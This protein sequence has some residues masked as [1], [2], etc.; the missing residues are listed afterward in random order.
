[1]ASDVPPVDLYMAGLNGQYTLMLRG[2]AFGETSPYLSVEPGSY[3]VALR[4]AGASPTSTPAVKGTVQVGDGKAYTF[5]ASGTLDNLNQKLIV[6]GP[7]GQAP[8]AQPGVEVGP[9]PT[10]GPQELAMTGTGLDVAAALGLVCV[11]F[12]TGLVLTGRR[13]MAAHR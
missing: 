7:A 4:P 2:L 10:A 8:S 9:T 1:M 13:R 12:G 5:L 6:D 3:S 11:A